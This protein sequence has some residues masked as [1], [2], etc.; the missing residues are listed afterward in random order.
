[1]TRDEYIQ[2]MTFHVTV[3]IDDPALATMRVAIG[4]ICSV[5]DVGA[6]PVGTELACQIL[7]N[8]VEIIETKRKIAQKSGGV[9]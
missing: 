2:W 9:E 7:N 8:E 3:A 4:E 1:M 6:P 5:V